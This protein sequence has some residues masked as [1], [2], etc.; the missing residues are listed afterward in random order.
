MLYATVAGWVDFISQMSLVELVHPQGSH[1]ISVVPLIN[2]CDLFKKSPGLIISPYRVQSEV[3]LDDFRDF[4]A[5]LEDKPINIDDSNFP[6]L[7]QL[8]EEFDFQALS[9]K[10][11]TP[12]RSPGLSA[13]QTAEC[14]SHISALEERS[15]EHEHQRAGLQSALFPALLRFEADLARLASELAAFRE[16][17]KGATARPAGV[18]DCC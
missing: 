7:S 6:G 9:K 3:S 12:R 18:T 8:F 2:K 5:V 4:V 15:V 14:L 11:S 17:K 16:T 13:A 10:L 1:Q